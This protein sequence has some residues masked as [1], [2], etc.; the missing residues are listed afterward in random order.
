MPPLRSQL[1]YQ[2]YQ[3]PPNNKEYLMII[4]AVSLTNITVLAPS[5]VKL[6]EFKVKLYILTH[7][8]VFTCPWAIASNIIVLD[9]LQ[10]TLPSDLAEWNLVPF[11]ILLNSPVK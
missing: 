8:T 3:N 6:I 4:I 5:L 10:R 1:K 2:V 11:S 9:L 7:F